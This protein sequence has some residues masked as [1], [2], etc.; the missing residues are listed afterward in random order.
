MQRRTSSRALHEPI[1]R[2][3]DAS[4]ALHPPFAAAPLQILEEAANIDDQLARAE[5]AQNTGDPVA[6]ARQ[7]ARVNASLRAIAASPS[8]SSPQRAAPESRAARLTAEASSSLRALVA[9]A[10]FRADPLSL[11]EALDA[12]RDLSGDEPA[13]SALLAALRA[14]LDPAARCLAPGGVEALREYFGELSKETA[15]CRDILASSG[16][17]PSDAAAAVIE[18]LGAS[19]KDAQGPIGAAIDHALSAGSSATTS[20]TSDGRAHPPGEKGRA[21]PRAPVRSLAGVVDEA[22]AFLRSMPEAIA[23]EAV[24]GGGSGGEEAEWTGAYL[25]AM[26]GALLPVLRGVKGYG[27]L[28]KAAVVADAARGV[29][30]V[31]VEK[32]AEMMDSAVGTAVAACERA[33]DGCAATTSMTEAQGLVSAVEA[34]LVEVMGR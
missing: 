26:L 1:H 12:L 3:E 30:A 23:G 34:G 31:E 18:A 9:G 29:R 28:E 27:A 17:S 19:T 21:D 16:M 33:V 14:R 7:L 2:T 25:G 5:E 8:A 20:T 32:M 10:V 4:N 6:A 11:A 24:V 15:A 22:S 13:S